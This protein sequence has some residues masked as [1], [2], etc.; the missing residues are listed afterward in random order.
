MIR[1]R[2]TRRNVR[3]PAREGEEGVGEEEE[4]EE[5]GYE[6]EQGEGERKKG[7]GNG[8]CKGEGMKE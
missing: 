8:E 3:P 2:S 4:V 7:R 5:E 6:R 1:W